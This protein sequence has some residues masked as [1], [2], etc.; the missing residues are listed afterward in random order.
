MKNRGEHYGV[1]TGIMLG[2]WI[3]LG[4]IV[5]FEKDTTPY[6]NGYK[7]G[8]VDAISGKSNYHKVTQKDFSITWEKISF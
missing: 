7:Q 8:Q 3:L 5:I 4:I 6:I 2:I 1:G